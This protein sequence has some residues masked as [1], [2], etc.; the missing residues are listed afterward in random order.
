MD[1]MNNQEEKRVQ[2]ALDDKEKNYKKMLEEEVK[3][4]IF[5]E[6]QSYSDE[7]ELW[8]LEGNVEI[9]F[10]DA[11]LYADKVS[12]NKFS[13]FIIAEGNVTV[14]AGKDLITGS[15]F[16]GNLSTG[17]GTFYDVEG[18][19]DP[20]YY[21]EGE[22]A[23]RFKKDKYRL[24]K[25][26][27]T[28]CEG[29]SPPWSFKLSKATIHVDNYVYI[30]NPIL[31]IKKMP[32]LY[33]PYWIYPI[34]PERTTGLLIPKWGYNSRDGF[35][36]KPGF[37]WP[38]RDNMDLKLGI[39]WA[40]KSGWGYN[41]V[42]RY[43]FSKTC[44]G[45]IKF[46]YKKDYLITGD[47]FGND[48]TDGSSFL[49]N[50]RISDDYTERWYGRWL[51]LQT[52]P[53]DVKNIINI[54]YVSD[55]EYFRDIERDIDQQRQEVTSDIS[56]TK[57]WSS[58]SLSLYAKYTEDLGDSE[59]HNFQAIQMIPVIK[60]DSLS[61][62]IFDLPPRYKFGF[63][64][65]HSQIQSKGNRRLGNLTLTEIKTMTDKLAFDINLSY[66]C[67]FLP[68]LSVTPSI[69][70]YET[71]YFKNKLKLFY[72]FE[73]EDDVIWGDYYSV[74]SDLSDPDPEQF[75]PKERWPEQVKLDGNNIRRDIY[76]AN[77]QIIGPQFYRIFN[78]KG[79][80][81]F[82]KI[83]HTIEPKFDFTYIPDVAYGY[84][85]EL[86]EFNYQSTYMILGDSVAPMNS[87]TYSLNN[88]FFGKIVKEG[89]SD[90]KREI[91]FINFSQRYDFRMKK[92]INKL[93]DLN[94][95]NPDFFLKRTEEPFSNI[96]TKIK[97]QPLKNYSINLDFDFD[98]YLY[99]FPR[100]QVDFTK[101]GTIFNLRTSWSYAESYQ[102][103]GEIKTG[104]TIQKSDYGYKESQNF[105]TVN[106]GCNLL[107]NKWGFQFQSR[108]NMK[109]SLF[110]KND[111]RIIYNSQ[112]WSLQLRLMHSQTEEIDY[113]AD[114]LER[115]TENDYDIEMIV[116]LRNVGPFE[117]L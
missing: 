78:S 108:Y 73:G 28:S 51:H 56:F 94:K 21:F 47:R 57:N 76:S 46:D 5:S 32:L 95:D 79:F 107:D 6:K 39:E 63:F 7:E 67:K 29:D 98:P 55:R 17:L 12:L 33:F 115:F 58:Y 31:F 26:K 77:L 109:E 23:V 59:T 44:G 84:G 53:Y 65:S 113:L 15:K 68:W 86:D 37:F 14:E 87:V 117:I 116:I 60:F 43:I 45:N 30:L 50:Q 52:Y 3:I 36:Y 110:I 8:L 16:V 49:S 11:R 74:F 82:E 24:H 102:L 25:G 22:K 20:L 100:W 27:F 81:D 69:T 72:N 70:L 75:F 19:I 104:E 38:I 80:F 101:Q 18:Y 41:A 89:E 4:V 71:W 85:S 92:K 1:S 35:Y 114:D 83:N 105:L 62:N 54:N 66:P 90:E 40:S 13:G 42:Y 93:E 106:M 99:D 10:G 64:Y 112:C 88:K 48:S 103:V 34:K 61:K 111:L 9:K 91:G 2:K 97:F 96:R